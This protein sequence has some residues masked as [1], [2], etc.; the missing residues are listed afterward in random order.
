M[1]Q[2]STANDG[3]LT[4]RSIGAIHLFHNDLPL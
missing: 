2:Q 4:S 3:S 1:M